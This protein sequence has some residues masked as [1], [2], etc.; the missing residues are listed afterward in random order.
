MRI[1][2]CLLALLLVFGVSVSHADEYFHVFKALVKV[3]DAPIPEVNARCTLL[4]GGSGLTAGD[5][6]ASYM[7]VSSMDVPNKFS[8]FECEGNEL[9]QCTLAYGM[10]DDAESPG[11]MTTLRF[12]YFSSTDTLDVHSLLCVTEP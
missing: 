8:S 1:V 4:A 5:Y 2:S 9:L 7:A 3:S 6:I 11:W 10:T 12:K